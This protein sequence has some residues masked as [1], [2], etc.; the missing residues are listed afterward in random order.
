[1]E[2]PLSESNRR[3]QP[4]HGC[5]LPTEL[6][7]QDRAQLTK[8]GTHH[9]PCRS[10][11]ALRQFSWSW[12][13]GVALRI[14]EGNSV[15][16]MEQR[17]PEIQIRSAEMSDA[18][19]L[20][21]IYNREVLHSTVTFD[22][23]PRDTAGQESWLREH[24]G[25]YPAIVAVIG[26]RLAGFAS[27]SPYR[28]RPAYSTTAEDSIYVHHDFRGQG[29]GKALLSDLLDRATAGGFHSVMARIVGGHDASIALHASL[30]F[31]HVGVEVEVGRKFGRW[32]DVAVMQKM[33]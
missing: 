23:V 14:E 6:R 10:V 28:P 30:G 27:L 15:P 31:G 20:A 11:G 18:C 33:L 22:L 24:S 3:H 4:Y 17:R 13:H 16:R 9:Y 26:G 12:P 19:A 29:V 25:A 5:A 7:G 1:M 21:S 32:L 8:P 2:S